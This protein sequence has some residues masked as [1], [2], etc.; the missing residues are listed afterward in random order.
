MR[1]CIIVNVR[2]SELRAASTFST[3]CTTADS[4]VVL[5]CGHQRREDLLLAIHVH[6]LRLQHR[7]RLLEDGFEILG[8]LR[9]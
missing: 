1:Y 3:A 9:R 6:L 4:L 7:Q 2:D 5:A 8:L